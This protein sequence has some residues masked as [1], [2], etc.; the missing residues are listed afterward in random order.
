MI[1]WIHHIYVQVP[2]FRAD[3]G[4]VKVEDVSAIAGTCGEAVEEVSELLKL[5]SRDLEFISC[6]SRIR[7]IR[8]HATAGSTSSLLCDKSPEAQAAHTKH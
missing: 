2:R 7:K 1:S 8:S 6:Q 4:V 3:R 5:S